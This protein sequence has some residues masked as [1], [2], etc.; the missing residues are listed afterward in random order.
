MN[1]LSKAAG[2]FKD[3]SGTFSKRDLSQFCLLETGNSD[4]MIGHDASLCTVFE[5][6]GTNRMGSTADLAEI[7]DAAVGI[8]SP[9]MRAPGYAIQFCFT[10]NPENA[11]TVISEL[12]KP[13]R[14][15][16][17]LMGMALDEILNERVDHL[18]KF[19]VDERVHLVL[20]TRPSSL[21]RIE[22]KVESRAKKS[23]GLAGALK[24]KAIDAQ[25]FDLLSNMMLNKHRALVEAVAAGLKGVHIEV[26][27]CSVTEAVRNIRESV[28]QKSHPGWRPF[29][30]RTASATT[31]MP[32]PRVPVVKD[33]DDFSH[34][35]WPDLASQIFDKPASTPDDHGVIIDGMRFAPI[36]ISCGP[37]NPPKPFNRLISSIR[38][39]GE[40]PWRMSFLMESMPLANL[41]VSFNSLIAMITAFTSSSSRLYDAAVNN[42]KR[43][44]I[45]ENGANVRIRMTATT[46]APENDVSLLDIRV[47]RIQRALESWGGCQTNLTS[48]D[49]VDSV[50]SSVPALD[51]RSTATAGIAPL[52]EA[53]SV[54]PWMREAS[55]WSG[56]SLLLR[57]MDG[58]IFPAQ[59]GSDKQ[60]AW[61]DIVI[62][63][64]GKGKS[65]FLNTTNMSFCLSPESAMGKGGA[66]LPRL[67][68]FDFGKSAMGITNLLRSALPAH[69]KSEVVFHTL[70][71]DKK[72][73]PFDLYPGTK[74][75]LPQQRAYLVN[76][77][78]TLV[79]ADRGD[80]PPVIRDGVMELVG[81]VI[82]T[83]YA[84]ADDEGRTSAPKRYIK[85]EN[86]EV[87]EAIERLSIP[88]GECRTWYSVCRGLMRRG[89]IRAATIANRYAVPRLEDL[90]ITENASIH[91][92]YS[93]E[94]TGLT[95][96]FE[97]MI[98]LAQNDY[99]ILN[100]VTDLD[101]SS[102]RVL[103][104]DL[105]AVAPKGHI[106]R[107]AVMY[108][109]AFQIG[110]GDV[111]ISEEDLPHIPE[112][113][114]VYY[115]GYIARL[116]EN[117]KRLV[118]DEY[119]R[120]SG[121]PTVQS[122]VGWVTREGRK[123][124]LQV[125][126]ATQQIYDIGQDMLNAATSVYVCGVNTPAERTDIA[127]RFELT[128][129]ASK[130]LST[131][132][133]GPQKFGAPV[134]ALHRLGGGLSH[135]H[136]L[137][138][139]V[140]PREA[141]AFS[142]SQK[143]ATLRDRLSAALGENEARKRL[144]ELYPSGS[145]DREINARS[146]AL[147]IETAIDNDQAET[148]AIDSILNEIIAGTHVGALVE[149]DD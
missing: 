108:I 22:Q 120:T 83:A 2:V 74:F 25:R 135:E 24:L 21:N 148:G 104:L 127:K 53:M 115:K 128:E 18:S 58:R 79:S 67:T 99:P 33:D 133:T 65:F 73:N 20:W 31:R 40:P 134:L 146:V 116:R 86:N 32:W 76:L 85:G 140:G 10:R 35:L 141:W 139:T 98:Q 70:T 46:W 90:L 88:D 36:D 114:R 63:A 9:F 12:V 100:G 15:T 5:V 109:L 45:E 110:M 17:K 106:K 56:G 137:V 29:I 69:R 38:D 117:Q 101:L 3:F 77:I 89:E 122:Q 95:N 28:Y 82:D 30:P 87:D 80:Q 97:R 144:S 52:P 84:I 57:T 78:S 72:V 44:E 55:P 27:R 4:I 68:I 129:A 121:V 48:G 81:R 136:I 147:A 125:C 75:P 43:Y 13:I 105:S 42:L 37:T 39:M 19:T 107:N 118:M 16:A 119:Q 143:S 50:L 47:N 94:T 14:R 1:I 92:L 112:E 7:V 96:E 126:V 64:M 8:F 113:F 66:K 142:T 91:A 71:A 62:G 54:M 60:D 11:K 34:L 131:I 41:A 61:V 51:V 132:V 149:L 23:A 130:A 145:A 102:A 59:L 93:N 124:T 138:N 26:K 111:Y 123:Y 103:A 49:L 6:G